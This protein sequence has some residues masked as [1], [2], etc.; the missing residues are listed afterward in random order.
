[1]YEGP[2][3]GSK[4]S[5]NVIAKM[6]STADS[7]ATAS[8]EGVIS[9]NGSIGGAEKKKEKSSFKKLFKSRKHEE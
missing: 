6:D 4:H 8:S 2:A 7:L 9:P 1:M 5:S 3:G